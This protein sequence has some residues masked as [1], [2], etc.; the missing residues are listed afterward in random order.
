MKFY[1]LKEKKSVMVPDSK[2]KYE[3]KNGRRMAMAT[4]PSCGA[5]MAK[6]VPKD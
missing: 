6:F 1:C 3:M 2:V 5:K 4:C